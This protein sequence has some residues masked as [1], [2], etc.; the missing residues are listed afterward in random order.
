MVTSHRD[1]DFSKLLN[2]C[3]IKKFSLFSTP[4]INCHKWYFTFLDKIKDFTFHMQTLLLVLSYCLLV[5]ILILE[6]ADLLQEI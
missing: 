4:A 2:L 3:P 6:N 1:T 5:T